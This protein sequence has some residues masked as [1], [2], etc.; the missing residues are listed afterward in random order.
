MSAPDSTGS[1]LTRIFDGLMKFCGEEFRGL[2]I[3]VPRRDLHQK[4]NGD[5][6]IRFFNFSMYPRISWVLNMFS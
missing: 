2:T 3:T 6:D 1:H 5:D 4:H